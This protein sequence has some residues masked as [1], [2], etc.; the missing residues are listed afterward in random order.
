MAVITERSRC[1][2][3]SPRSKIYY[4]KSATKS[5]SFSLDNTKVNVATSR[6]KVP[7]ADLVFMPYTT[8]NNSVRDTLADKAAL[9]SADKVTKLSKKLVGRGGHAMWLLSLVSKYAEISS[10]GTYSGSLEIYLPH[11]RIKDSIP[12]E[13][14]NRDLLIAV[15]SLIL[16]L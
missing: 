15:N 9:P 2:S 7:G 3:Q 14:L 13:P 1:S 8:S 11:K 12:F 5:P 16:Y 4:N 6:P 10:N